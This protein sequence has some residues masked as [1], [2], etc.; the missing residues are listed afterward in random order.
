MF[1]IK[2]TDL[3]AN[4]YFVALCQFRTFPLKNFATRARVFSWGG[5]G[6]SYNVA[7]TTDQGKQSENRP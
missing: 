3:N 1:E 7:V 4:L 5:G 2:I 6:A